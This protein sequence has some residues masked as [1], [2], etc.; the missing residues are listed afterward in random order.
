MEQTRRERWSEGWERELLVE[1]GDEGWSHKQHQRERKKSL[2]GQRSGEQ[3]ESERRK[4][5]R[6]KAI[7]DGKNF[8]ER[9]AAAR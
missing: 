6:R 9:D 7:D 2:R 1:T 5:M 4:R 8:E 3:R